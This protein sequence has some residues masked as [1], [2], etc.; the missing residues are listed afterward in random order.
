MPFTSTLPEVGTNNP[1]IIF[2]VVVLPA[3]FGPTKPKISPSP[4]VRFNRSAATTCA[5]FPFTGGRSYSLVRFSRRTIVDQARMR[6]I[7]YAISTTVN[8]QGER[9]VGQF[10]FSWR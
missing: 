4:M 7:V 1:Q 10:E 6:R 8:T 2:S 3:P 5:G 9:V